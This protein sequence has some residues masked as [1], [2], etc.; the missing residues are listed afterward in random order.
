MRYWM[1]LLVILFIQ[2]GSIE[3]RSYTLPLGGHPVAVV[4]GWSVCYGGLLPSDSVFVLAVSGYGDIFYPVSDTVISI[5]S[6]RFAVV[7]VGPRSVVLRRS[8]RL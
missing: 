4:S 6:V 3:S 7:S 8:R 1:M 2:C 5:Y